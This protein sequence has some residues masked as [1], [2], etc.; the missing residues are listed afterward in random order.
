[1]IIAT[2]RKDTPAA[3]QTIEHDESGFRLTGGP[4]LNDQQ[5]REYDEEGQL[6]WASE[7]LRR[8]AL[9]PTPPPPSDTPAVPATKSVGERIF[10]GLVVATIVFAIFTACLWFIALG[11]AVLTH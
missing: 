5:V 4:S 8:S 7:S 11:Y 10:D 9:D 3:G 1:M 2:F 6:E